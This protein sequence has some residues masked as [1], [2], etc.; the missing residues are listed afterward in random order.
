MVHFLQLMNLHWHIIIIQSPEFTL[1]FML[2]VVHYLGF[3]KGLMIYIFIIT[4]SCRVNS[5]SWKSF[6]LHLFIPFYLS[7][8]AT[9]DLFSE[10]QPLGIFVTLI[11]QESKTDRRVLQVLSNIKGSFTEEVTVLGRRW[12]HVPQNQCPAASQGPRTIKR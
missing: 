3:D 5:L 11:T 12:T 10:R 7:S 4:I 9:T 6:L 2:G 8:L 1:E